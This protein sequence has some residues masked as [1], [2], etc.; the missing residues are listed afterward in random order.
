MLFKNLITEIITKH[1]EKGRCSME[2]VETTK[3]VNTTNEIGGLSGVVVFWILAIFFTVSNLHFISFSFIDVIS[4][5]DE[6]IKLFD[7]FNNCYWLLLFIYA[8]HNSVNQNK[9][10]RCGGKIVKSTMFVTI[11]L[12]ILRYMTICCPGVLPEFIHVHRTSDVMYDNFIV[13]LMTFAYSRAIPGIGGK[14]LPWIKG[15]FA[16]FIAKAKKGKL[17][18]SIGVSENKEKEA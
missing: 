7:Q 8:S 2:K 11:A 13:V 6:L 14:F 5:E 10:K 3:A 12:S 15:P 1:Q 9:K 18:I 16:E 4:K 17:N